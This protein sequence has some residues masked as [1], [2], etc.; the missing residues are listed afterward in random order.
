[1]EQNKEQSEATMG[2]HMHTPGNDSRVLKITAWLTGVYF[3]I[4]L[5]L[6]IYSGSLAVLSDAFHTFSA[7]GGVL[8][9]LVAHRIAQQGPKPGYT[10][11][12]KRAEI[13]GALLN[14]LLLLLMAFY[15]L[16]MGYQRLQ[17][18][19]E[20]P[21]L[22]MYLAAF[23]GLVTEVISIGVMWKSLKGNYNMQGAFWHVLQTFIGSLIVIVAAIVIQLTGWYPIDPILGMLFGV[24]LAWASWGIIR[25]TVAILMQFGPADVDVSQVIKRLENLDGVKD[26][27]HPHAWVLTSSHN[28]FSAHIRIKEDADHDEVLKSAHELLKESFQFYF[29]TLQIEKT[30]LN[31]EN[32]K[33]ID[34]TK[35]SKG[36]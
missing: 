35:K 28:I 36:N 16:W 31:E 3:F 13:V 26:V 2:H 30:C 25:D 32:A 24:V 18:P 4:E 23:G 14:G 17:E 6:G 22:P 7:V 1:M 21:T 9:A 29:S 11:G 10:F 5:G 12:L 34:L 15:I 8:L 19:M 27:H 20:I 33:D